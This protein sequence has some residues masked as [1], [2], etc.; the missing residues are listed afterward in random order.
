MAAHQG[1]AERHHVITHL[2]ELLVG[3][4]GAQVVHR[5]VRTD[6]KFAVN[7]AA[8][9]AADFTRNEIAFHVGAQNPTAIDRFFGIREHEFAAP[10]F[11]QFF[12]DSRRQHQTARIIK[13]I[14]PD[15]TTPPGAEQHSPR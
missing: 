12:G 15:G 9:F 11:Q 6:F 10:R 4:T 2:A 8:V 13:I 1:Y 14:T 5:P 7:D 3:V